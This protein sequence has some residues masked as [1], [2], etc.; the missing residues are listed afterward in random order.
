VWISSSQVVLLSWVPATLVTSEVA[1][2]GAVFQWL[3]S[4]GGGRSRSVLLRRRRRF[5]V[6]VVLVRCCGGSGC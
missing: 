6:V 3:H 1:P 5:G 4:F 2:G